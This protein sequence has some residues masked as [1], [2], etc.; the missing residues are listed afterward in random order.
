MPHTHFVPA[1]CDREQVMAAAH[2]AQ[3]V[4]IVGFLQ[5]A[6]CLEPGRVY[7]SPATS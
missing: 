1:G 6:K 7:R 3:H 5:T 2:L 4:G